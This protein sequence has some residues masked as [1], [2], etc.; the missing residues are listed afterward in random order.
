MGLGVED[1]RYSGCKQGSTY[2]VKCTFAITDKASPTEGA[3][4]A[5]RCYLA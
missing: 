3:V 2:E 1:R 4:S 5:V